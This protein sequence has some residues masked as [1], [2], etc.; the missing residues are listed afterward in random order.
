M[1]KQT[2]VVKPNAFVSRLRTEN[3]DA[4]EFLNYV[5]NAI[6]EILLRHKR[7]YVEKLKLLLPAVP[8]NGESDVGSEGSEKKAYKPDT[9]V[10]ELF[11]GLLTN[12]TKCLT[13]ETDKFYCDVCKSLQ[14]AEKRMK[15]KSL[16]NILAVHLKRFKY[17]ENL[18]RFIKLNYRVV[19]PFE[20]KLFNTSDDAEDPDRLYNLSSIIIHLGIGPHQGHYISIVKSNDH[21]ILFDDENV[22]RI[23]EHELSRFFGDLNQPGTGY[24]FFYE[25]VGFDVSD[26]LERMNPG[27]GN[28][29]TSNSSQ[30]HTTGDTT[31]NLSTTS[32][33]VPIA[34]PTTTSFGRDEAAPSKLVAS[35]V[36][37]P[38]VT[39]TA[40]GGSFGF[41]SKFKRPSFH[42]THPNHSASEQ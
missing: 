9:W 18:Q 24:M 35:T 10:H 15:I 39:S 4:Q 27:K 19:F 17:Q 22:D 6:A 31:L 25:R 20:L 32:G 7:E 38:P 12:E 42:N 16:P 33:S 29:G 28:M 13:C 8:G 14:E 1:K 3:Q 5:L 2:G 30:S 34:I 23:E 21:W 37:P 36:S 40:G 26:I 11:E 41:G